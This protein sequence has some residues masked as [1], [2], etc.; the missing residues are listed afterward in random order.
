[1][2]KTFI[3][4]FFLPFPLSLILAA[5][6]LFFLWKASRPRLAKTLLTISFVLLVTGSGFGIGSFL[7]AGLECRHLPVLN[8]DALDPQGRIQDIVILGAG[9]NPAPRFPPNARHHE[10]QLAR[11]VEGARLYHSRPGS[12]IIVSEG[13]IEEVAA[14]EIMADTL[15]SLS[16]PRENILLEGL[17]HT[18]FEQSHNIAP[19]VDQR[20]FFLVTSALH[21]PRALALFQKAGLKPVPAPTNFHSGSCDGK[22]MGLHF[23]SSGQINLVERSLY[24]YIGW[25]KEKITGHL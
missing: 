13:D 15:V 2:L 8:P 5:A 23:P 6:G 7:A 1:M 12:R 10:A 19:L 20:E 11:L 21:M 16:V 22:A 14:T 24:E 17:S 9:V 4:R 25:M 3:L 18:T